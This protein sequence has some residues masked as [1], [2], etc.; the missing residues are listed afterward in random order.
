V[1]SAVLPR[2]AATTGQF[3]T[4]RRFEFDL[5]VLASAVEAVVAPYISG[6]VDVD[7][8]VPAPGEMVQVLSDLSR[9]D[10]ETP[11]EESDLSQ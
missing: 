1:R 3:R 2:I 10:L 5:A 4:F 11:D 9:P 7:G 6:P 8:H